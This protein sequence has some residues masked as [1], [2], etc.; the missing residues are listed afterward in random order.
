M[1]GDGRGYRV[2]DDSNDVRGMFGRGRQR[3]LKAV[4][5]SFVDRLAQ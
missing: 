2:T 5:V 4:I 3:G 1:R